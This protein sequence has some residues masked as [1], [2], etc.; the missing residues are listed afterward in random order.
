MLPPSGKPNSGFSII[1]VGPDNSDPYR[2]Q[3]AVIRALGDHFGIALDRSRCYPYR[4]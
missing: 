1:I 3:S 4:R 2:N